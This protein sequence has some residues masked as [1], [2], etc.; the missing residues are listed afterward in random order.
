MLI[1]QLH[2]EAH[3]AKFFIPQRNN[4]KLANIVS[5]TPTETVEK[6]FKLKVNVDVS[7]RNLYVIFNKIRVE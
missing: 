2:K 5:V 6:L 1:F 7:G 4:S 3:S